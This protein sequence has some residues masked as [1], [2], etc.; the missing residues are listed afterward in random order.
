MLFMCISLH[1]AS[2]NRVEHSPDLLKSNGSFKPFE[3]LNPAKAGCDINVEDPCN[4]H[5]EVKETASLK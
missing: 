1:L 3:G 5:S 2:K 4:V